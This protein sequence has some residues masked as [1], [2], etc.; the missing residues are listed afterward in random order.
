MIGVLK[1]RL[2]IKQTVGP[3]AAGIALVAPDTGRVL[4][5]QR[6]LSG[7]DLNGGKWEFPG[8]RLEEGE[9]PL[10][11][12]IREWEEETGLELPG[13]SRSGGFREWRSSDGKYV[14]YVLDG[15]LDSEVDLDFTE[16]DL[17]SD[18]DSKVGGV[19][20]WVHPRDMVNHNLRPELLADVDE[21][22]ARIVKYLLGQ[23]RKT[24]PVNRLKGNY[25]SE[26]DRDDKGRCLPSGA[27]S[28]EKP[29][30]A[31]NGG[32]RQV[33][34]DTVAAAG[35]RNQVE[36]MSRQEGN[37]LEVLG[38]AGKEVHI[39]KIA[40]GDEAK[41]KQRWEN[42]KPLVMPYNGDPEVESRLSSAW[43]DVS[44]LW[45]EMA[46]KLPSVR[47]ATAE[48]AR[49]LGA[50]TAALN[51][52]TGELII[53]SNT[54]EIPAEI[55][56]HELVHLDQKL[57]GDLGKEPMY[58]TNGMTEHGRRME[59]EAHQRGNMQA[60]DL[61]RRLR[62]QKEPELEESDG[63]WMTLSARSEVRKYSVN[64]QDKAAA[65]S[66]QSAGRWLA[67]KWEQLEGRYG[68]SV[69]LT[70]AVTMLATLP[71][72]G[73]IVAV[74]AAA[75]GIRG[76]SGYF[77][78]G[79][80]RLPVNRLKGL[81]YSVRKEGTCS[82]GETAVQTGCTPASGGGG[83]KPS[84]VKPRA[85]PPGSQLEPKM[86]AKLK[87]LGADKLPPADVPVSDI[88]VNLDAGDSG[89]LMTWKQTSRSGRVSQQSAYTA[90]FHARNAEEKWKRVQAIEPHIE[91]IGEGLKKSLQ[92]RKLPQRE[93]EAAAIASFIRETG[94]R[95]TD[96]AES[97]KHGHF[98]ISSLQGRHVKVKGDKVHL[99]FIGKEGVRNRTV[100]RDP[101]NVE[102]VKEVMKSTGPKDFLFKEASSGDAIKTL[103]AVSKDVGGPEDI[104]IKDLRTVNATRWGQE[105]VKTFKGPPPPLSGDAK[106][107][108]KLIAKAVLEMS[109]EVSKRLNNNPAMAR[110]NYIHPK[111]FKQW[112][113]TLTSRS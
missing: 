101:A 63:G 37:R 25:F 72:P 53:P 51:T 46:G 22:L 106:K 88:K 2:Q 50:S 61:F 57:R 42:N 107:D 85:K 90:A 17:S 64:R 40:S 35:H 93:R 36:Q 9:E 113:L 5:I 33:A 87:E 10:E 27:G 4:M 29:S 45:P 102:F 21:V 28:S 104:L 38:D 24:G 62:G 76:L 26:C 99:D 69:A 74:V 100:I 44:K 3:V 105:A 78:R 103:K 91:A 95:P 30:S 8:G 98:G 71:V 12:A 86:L 43:E 11:A 58:D 70:M 81:H 20:A 55:L 49:K 111:V 92:D 23:V 32:D 60:A 89:A 7:D 19:L 59:S 75:E 112:L 94:L 80:E 79:N 109:G 16:R 82:V 68:R 84:E 77:Q 48:E 15:V 31:V 54:K 67:S 39:D 52:S 18:P 1:N 97:I 65:D 34:E 56:W 110:D 47:M 108:S 14:G 41:A 96:G 6:Q 73:N 13:Y 83:K 66:I